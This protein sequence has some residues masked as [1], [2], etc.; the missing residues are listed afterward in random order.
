VSADEVEK[1]VRG[2]MESKEGKMIR[3]RALAMKNEAKAALSEGGSSH[4]ALSKLLE[5]WKHE[6]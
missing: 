1:K 4:V 6:K 3:E 2:L 5:S